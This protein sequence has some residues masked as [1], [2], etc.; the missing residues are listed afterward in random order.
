MPFQ[1]TQVS[2]RRY[3]IKTCYTKNF[4]YKFKLPRHPGW[5]GSITP[6][7]HHALM[8]RLYNLFQQSF[9]NCFSRN[10]LQMLTWARRLE[11][12]VVQSLHGCQFLEIGSIDKRRSVGNHPGHV[13]RDTWLAVSSSTFRSGSACPASPWTL[14]T[15]STGTGWWHPWSMVM[16]T[17]NSRNTMTMTM[18]CSLQWQRQWQWPWHIAGNS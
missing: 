1:R 7:R 5:D 17:M 18:T 12:R 3:E 11:T 13:T 14:P 9:S 8:L 4:Q 15:A 10:K 16:Q 6:C 2:I